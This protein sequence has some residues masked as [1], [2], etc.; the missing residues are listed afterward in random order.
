[1]PLAIFPMFKGAGIFMHFLC[2][3]CVDEFI[4][5]MYDK[6]IKMQ[7]SFFTKKC[8]H[9][10]HYAHPARFRTPHFSSDLCSQHLFFVVVIVAVMFAFWRQVLVIAG[11]RARR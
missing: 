9:S 11:Y 10:P 8:L 2:I 5:T 1:M 4:E 3:Y 6:F 7:T